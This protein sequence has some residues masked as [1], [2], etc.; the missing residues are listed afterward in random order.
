MKYNMASRSITRGLSR[1]DPSSPNTLIVYA[2]K[3]GS[4]AADGDDKN[5]PFTTALVKYLPRPGLDLRKAF[6]FVRDDV[7]K[8]THNRQEPFVYGSLGGDDVALVPARAA[9]A[10]DR[11]ADGSQCIRTGGLRTALKFNVVSAWERD[12]GDVCC[13]TFS[14]SGSSCSSSRTRPSRMISMD[15][16]SGRLRCFG[17]AWR[18]AALFN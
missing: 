18:A 2:A 11:G 13:A 14:D 10:P 7:L 3:A 5:S 15:S 8:V 16:I 9:N 6:G 17:K 1:I 12:H 4:T